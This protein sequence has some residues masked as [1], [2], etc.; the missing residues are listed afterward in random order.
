MFLAVPIRCGARVSA[1]NARTGPPLDPVP[2]AVLLWV[3]LRLL[4]CMLGELA[5]G[6]LEGREGA[7][8][9]MVGFAHAAAGFA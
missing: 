2:G 1:L 6:G 3:F 5:L 4:D 7:A 9:G 8:R